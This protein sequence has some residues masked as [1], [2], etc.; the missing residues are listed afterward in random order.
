VSGADPR[1]WIAL[2]II[3]LAQLMVVLDITIVNIALPSA[4]NELHISDADRQWVVTAYTLAFG[5]LLLLGGRI[6]DYTGRK[7][8]FVIG[9]LGFAA[10]SAIGGAATSTGMLLGARAAQGVFGALLTPSALS[11]LTTTFRDPRERGKAFAVYGAVAAGGSAVGLVLG[12]VL[13]EYLDWRWCLYVNVPIAAVA[14]VGALVA[15]TETR[16]SGKARYDV[17]GVLTATGG[18][19]ALVYGFTKA[20]TDGWRADITVELIA[21]GAALLVVFLIIENFVANPLLPVRIIRHRSRGGADLSVM[22]GVLGM[23]GVFFFLNFYLQGILH[24]STVKTGLAFLPMTGGVLAAS[25]VASSLIHRIP[26]R[27]LIG[28]GLLIAAGGMSV[29]TRLGVHTSYAS[30]VLPGLILVGFGLGLVFVPAVN[31]ATFGVDPRDAG[32]ASA[33]VNTAQQVGGSLGTALLNTIAANATASYLDAHGHNPAATLAG[34][35]HGYNVGNTWGAGILAVAG[36]LALILI[37]APKLGARSVEAIATEEPAA[38]GVSGDAGDVLRALVGAG[39]AAEDGGSDVGIPDSHSSTALPG[40]G[41]GGVMTAGPAGGLAHSVRGHIRQA[42]GT[43]VAGAVITLLDVTGGQAGRSVTRDDGSYELV[44]PNAGHYVLVARANA[45]QPHAST[46][47]VNG[48]PMDLDVVLIGS[49][50]ITGIVRNSA[51]EPVTAAAVTITDARGDVV[52]N[53][54]TRANGSYDIDDLVVGDYTLVVSA[55][56]FRPA[57][58]LVTVPASGKAVQDV[59]LVGGA[60]LVGVARGGSGHV[61][62]PDARVTLMDN[63]GHVVAVARTDHDGSYRFSDLR[64]GRYTVIAT[65]YPPVT[66]VVD[67]DSV[68]E[69]EHD[70]ELGFPDEDRAPAPSDRYPVSSEQLVRPA[71]IG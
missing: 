52:A 62:L 10:A 65:G 21:G 56:A 39:T 69:L 15:I 17:P 44:A 67:I 51:G 64:N 13:T 48:G 12:G 11:L 7:R 61:P 22:L 27:F 16:V 38:P 19:V 57:A 63:A 6:A 25:A 66:E 60:R 14:A 53:C 45:H 30:H 23:F 1:R 37:N 9:L 4:Q 24:Y 54:V 2:P 55:H 68:D 20:Q 43:P 26:P 46:I 29:L 41:A 71:E 35:V 36:V 50:G 58:M 70:I 33:S 8:T 5:G 32:V 31:T 47:E 18:L 28:P 59:D 3:A 34:T 42:S 40:V 49:S